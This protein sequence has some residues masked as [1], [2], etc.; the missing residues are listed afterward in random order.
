MMDKT[1]VIELCV[2]NN[3]SYNNL[4]ISLVP[5]RARLRR[6][7]CDKY[8]DAYRRENHGTIKVTGNKV[9]IVHTLLSMYSEGFD[10]NDR[11]N[12]GIRLAV[13][14]SEDLYG[15][16]KSLCCSGMVITRDRLRKMM[17]A[18]EVSF[19]KFKECL[20]PYLLERE[21]KYGCSKEA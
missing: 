20:A 11:H 12:D 8:V 17:E 13:V 7:P 18:A 3:Y 16:I 15:T 10:M 14:V 21:L 9:V 5:Q 4:C 2:Y 6:L 1:G 19:G